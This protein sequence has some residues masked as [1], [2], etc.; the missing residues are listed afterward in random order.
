[1]EKTQICIYDNSVKMRREIWKDG[2][3]IGEIDSSILFSK[4]YNADNQQIP[5]FDGILFCYPWEA[6]KF[7]FGTKDAMEDI[8]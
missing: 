3:L 5:L 7:H 1:M 4:D 8:L 2:I 6:G